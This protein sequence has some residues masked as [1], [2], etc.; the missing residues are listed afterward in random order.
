MSHENDCDEAMAHYLPLRFLPYA[1][2]ILQALITT[3]VATAGDLSAGAVEHGLHQRW[4]FAWG[5]AWVTMLPVVLIASPLIQR[6]VR[7]F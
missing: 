4:M 5:V 7:H 2:G 6:A 3:A 1:Y